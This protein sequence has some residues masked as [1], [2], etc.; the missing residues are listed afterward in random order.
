[1]GVQNSIIR[2]IH[3]CQ[4]S[5]EYQSE[6]YYFCRPDPIRGDIEKFIEQYRHYR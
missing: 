5:A 2:D 4:D 6:I 1:M 3:D